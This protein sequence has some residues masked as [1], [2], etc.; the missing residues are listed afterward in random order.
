[1]AALTE[2]LVLG[3]HGDLRIVAS[4][5]E[6]IFFLLVDPSRPGCCA[7]GSYE[8]DKGWR[9]FRGSYDCPASELSGLEQV[10]HIEDA[11]SVLSAFAML[12]L[13]DREAAALAQPRR[14][15]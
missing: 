15:P 7:G 6:P 12:F 4:H 2:A 3:G 5:G 8:A 11:S 10:T 14:R 1:M 13:R 9:F